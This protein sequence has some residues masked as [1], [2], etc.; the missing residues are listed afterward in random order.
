M[1]I[2]KP[3]NKQ[4]ETR[5]EAKLYLGGTNKYNKALKDGDIYI[6]NYNSIANNGTLYNT[7]KKH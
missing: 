5:K 4:F 2:Y 6:T 3:H 1:Y 7:N